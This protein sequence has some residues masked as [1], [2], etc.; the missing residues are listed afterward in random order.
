MLNLPRDGRI[1]TEDEIERIVERAVD[2]LDREFL[3]GGWTQAEYDAE[4]AAIAIWA[5]TEHHFSRASK[6]E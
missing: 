6:G 1:R 2:R 4:H 5:K 3:R